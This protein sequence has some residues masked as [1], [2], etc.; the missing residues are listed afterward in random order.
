MVIAVTQCWWKWPLVKLSDFK[1][2][3]SIS[4]CLHWV[5]RG[6]N[7]RTHNNT[8]YT[9]QIKMIAEMYSYA[10]LNVTPFIIWWSLLIRIYQVFQLGKQYCIHIVH[11]ICLYFRQSKC[12]VV[13]IQPSRP[14]TQLVYMLAIGWNTYQDPTLCVSFVQI[15]KLLK[16]PC[17]IIISWNVRC[18]CQI[19]RI[20]AMKTN[21][22]LYT[23]TF[24]VFPWTLIFGD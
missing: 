23:S 24:S 22:S 6:P 12:T 16:T 14:W 20:E 11:S 7:D 19:S 9:N 21:C 2:G 15:D 18:S 1:S 17:M 10:W 3:E 8:T 4:S 5:Y 13:C